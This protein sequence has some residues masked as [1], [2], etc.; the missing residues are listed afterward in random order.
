[1]KSL[2]YLPMHST[3]SIPLFLSPLAMPHSMQRIN[4]NPA[5]IYSSYSMALNV[6]TYVLYNANHLRWKSLAVAKLNYILLE[7]I[8]GWMVVLHGQNLLHTL[9]H[10]K[11]FAVTD[12]STKTAT[13]SSRMICNIQY[14]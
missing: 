2:A 8:C 6:A 10:W 11:S 13:L 9:F 7:N 5:D 14:I 12:R 3:S 1:M 4:R